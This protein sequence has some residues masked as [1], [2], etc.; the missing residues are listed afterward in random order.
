M[1][2]SSSSVA[3]R[4]RI[5]RCASIATGDSDR[6]CR[7]VPIGM[8]HTDNRPGH[9]ADQLAFARERSHDVH[10]AMQLRKLRMYE[11]LHSDANSGVRRGAQALMRATTSR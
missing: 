5:A 7:A 4:W 9:R 11:G 3:L 1:R 6:W 10:L 8:P 2:S